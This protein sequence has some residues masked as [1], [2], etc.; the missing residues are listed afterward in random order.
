MSQLKKT[1]IDD[2]GFFQMPRGTTAERPVSPQTG[3]MRFNTSLNIM[4]WY[5]DTY[6]AW[7]PAGVIPPIATGGSISNITQSGFNY[8]VHTFATIGATT[9]TVTR[10]GLVEY[11]IVAGGGGGADV[12]GG[13]AGGVLTGQI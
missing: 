12:G 7:F 6:T 13:G 5:D 4:E 8:R 9:F 11:L 10:G 2:T 1:T 3:Q